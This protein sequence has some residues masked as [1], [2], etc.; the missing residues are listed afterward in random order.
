MTA[1]SKYFIG[2]NLS[3]NLNYSEFSIT[4]DETEDLESAVVSLTDGF[5]TYKIYEQYSNTNLNPAD[6]GT[7]VETGKVQV[8]GTTTTI[9]V[10]ENGIVSSF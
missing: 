8:T 6:S 1:E 10:D 7:L 2:E 4:E 5:W 3:S 9:Q